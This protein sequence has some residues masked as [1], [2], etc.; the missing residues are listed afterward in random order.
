MRTCQN[1]DGSQVYW[2]FPTT[3]TATPTVTSHN[4]IIEYLLVLLRFVV[5]GCV[6]TCIA[7][8][9]DPGSVA[10]TTDYWELFL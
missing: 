8:Q 3:L 7:F 6:V 1:I 5:I 4:L 10:G 2:Q 9:V